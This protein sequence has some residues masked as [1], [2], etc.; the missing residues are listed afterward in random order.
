MCE[1]CK[2][3][4]RIGGNDDSVAVVIKLFWHLT[5]SASGQKCVMDVILAAIH[6]IIATFPLIGLTLCLRIRIGPPL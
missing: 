6:T 5:F 4:Q 3:P 1:I 2:M